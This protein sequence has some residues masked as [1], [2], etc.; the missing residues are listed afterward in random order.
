MKLIISQKLLLFSFIILGGN[1]LLSYAVYKSKQ[2][3]IES[4]KWVEHTEQVIYQCVAMF[5]TSNEIKTASR[6]FILT[7]NKTH[8]QELHSASKKVFAYIENIKLLTQNNPSQKPNIDSLNIYM[9]MQLAFALKVIEI[10]NKYG[11]TSAINYVAI[12]NDNYYS[13]QIHKLTT[14]IQQGEDVLLHERRKVNARS[15]DVFNKLFIFVFILMTGF[16]IVMLF[17]VRKY[18]LQ[19]KEKEKRAAE[20]NCANEEL[21]FQNKVRE[22]AEKNLSQSESRLKEAQ[23]IAHVGNFEVD[24]ITHSEVWSD[25]MYKIYGIDKNEVAASKELFLSFIHP[26]DLNYITTNI[27]ECFKSFKSSASDFRFM[28]KDGSVRYAYSEAR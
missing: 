10:R 7:N 20:L 15:L 9:H 8:I 13:R 14:I 17:A 19:T 3:L 22:I 27:N 16:T 6:D 5:S 23:T 1:F 25:E 11:L 4:E 2:N 24:I 21:L 28:H 26:D 18:L 12:H